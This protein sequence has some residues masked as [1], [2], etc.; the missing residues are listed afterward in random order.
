MEKLIL[1]HEIMQKALA[2]LN[3]ALQLLENTNINNEQYE[4]MRDGA[5]QRFEYCIDLFWKY[6]KLQIESSTGLDITI[7]NPKE[8]IRLAVSHQIISQEELIILMSCVAQRNLSSHTYDEALA[9]NIKHELLTY[10]ACMNNI[11][12]RLAR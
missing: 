6:L 8:I 7:S 11:L 9:E 10:H 4:L 3:K 1:R 5:I 2:S 12:Q